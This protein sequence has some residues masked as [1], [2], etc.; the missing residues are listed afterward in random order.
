[1]GLDQSPGFG[2]PARGAMFFNRC[3]QRGLSAE[4]LGRL[5]GRKLRLTG[6]DAP[7]N[8]NGRDLGIRTVPIRKITGSKG[9]ANDFDRFFRPLQ[10]NTRERWLNVW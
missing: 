5:L 4:W 8:G 6:L 1:M 10:D 2:S 3:L 7:L 9:R